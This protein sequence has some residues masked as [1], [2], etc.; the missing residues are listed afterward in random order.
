V[1]PATV[2]VPPIAVFPLNEAAPSSNRTHALVALG[3]PPTN[4]M[5]SP[6]LES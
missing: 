4:S 5:V 3:L 6:L 2:K 1:T